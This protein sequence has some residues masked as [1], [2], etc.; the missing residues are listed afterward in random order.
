MRRRGTP[1]LYELTQSGGRGSI[2]AGGGL[3]GGSTPSSSPFGADATRSIRVPV[4]FLWLLLIAIIGL[5][6]LAYIFGVGRGRSSGF[7]EG[8]SAKINDDKTLAMNKMVKDPLK[9]NGSAGSN[10]APATTSAPPKSSANNA[11]GTKSNPKT[12]AKTDSKSDTRNAPPAAPSVD[13]REKGVNYLTLAR[14]S[15]D[16]ADNML[17]F[18]RAEGLAAYLVSDNNAKSRKVIVLPGLRTKAALD[19][20]EGQELLAK[21]K[22]VGQR[23]KAQ[24]KGNRDFSDAYLELFR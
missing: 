5:A 9:E 12:E 23:W 18:C 3:S 4:G 2:S 16:Q 19:T 13:P 20:K 1:T 10:A 6:V 24:S 17:A 22:S 21:V 15:G 14:P 8:F 11:P 7:A